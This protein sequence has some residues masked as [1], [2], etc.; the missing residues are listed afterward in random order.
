L[1]VITA[2]NGFL[3]NSPYPHTPFS[4]RSNKRPYTGNAIATKKVVRVLQNIATWAFVA[5]KGGIGAETS[6]GIHVELWIIG[7]YQI[8]IDQSLV[9]IHGTYWIQQ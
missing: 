1:Y 7:G 3:E 6:V 5:P 2:K 9:S 8:F 4:E